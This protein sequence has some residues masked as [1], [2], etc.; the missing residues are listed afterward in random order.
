MIDFQT[1]FFQLFVNKDSSYINN[2]N[3]HESRS[4]TLSLGEFCE[5]VDYCFYNPCVNGDCENVEDDYTCDCQDGYSGRN[6]TIEDRCVLDNVQ[7]VNGDCI[8]SDGSCDCQENWI[9]EICDIDNP[10]D[11]DPCNGGTCTVDENLTDITC[12]CLDH[13]SGMCLYLL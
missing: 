5:D 10:C 9:G 1:L 11:P 3:R 8:P 12:E 13:Y 7:C 2:L 4:K 6:C